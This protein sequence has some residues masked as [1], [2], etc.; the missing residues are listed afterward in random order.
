VVVAASTLFDPANEAVRDEEQSR[1]RA[2]AGEHGGLAQEIRVQPNLLWAFR[3]GG[4]HWR[5]A[6]RG[7]E[8]AARMG[9]VTLS[10]RRAVWASFDPL[11]GGE[12]L[13]PGPNG[14][15]GSSI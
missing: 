1:A 5:R 11:G 4:S 13:K 7:G 10:R 2:A 3:L 6:R 14:R 8:R 15:P 9:P 12:L